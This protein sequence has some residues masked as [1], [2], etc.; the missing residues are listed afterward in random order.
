M[1]EKLSLLR[2]KEKPRT[3]PW[4]QILRTGS[5]QVELTR[6]H[7]TSFSS[8]RAVRH[9]LGYRSVYIAL[10]SENF[11]SIHEHGRVKSLST[12]R[13][14][15]SELLPRFPSGANSKRRRKLSRRREILSSKKLPFPFLCRGLKETAAILGKEAAAESPANP[16]KAVGSL[17][18]DFVLPENWANDPTNRESIGSPTRS[19]CLD[20]PADRRPSCFQPI[21]ARRPQ[22]EVGSFAN[23]QT[24]PPTG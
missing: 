15:M 20:I 19:E 11:V 10:R 17:K 12:P 2:G 8:R 9:A 24:R 7:P 3:V 13:F 4:K 22:G 23:E 16:S 21:A 5:K 14:S 6:R 18:G 1:K